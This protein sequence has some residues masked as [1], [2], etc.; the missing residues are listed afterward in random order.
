MDRNETVE[1]T[2]NARAIRDEIAKTIKLG[3]RSRF[4]LPLPSFIPPGTVA[5]V[6]KATVVINA[7]TNEHEL[8]VSFS[9][10]PPSLTKSLCDSMKTSLGV[11]FSL[12][13]LTKKP[14]GTDCFTYCQSMAIK[15]T[16]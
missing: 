13:R 5:V 7:A 11:L 6:A 2:E 12:L 16:V 1:V 14:L 8:E 15:L 4:G 10:F 3:C 9:H